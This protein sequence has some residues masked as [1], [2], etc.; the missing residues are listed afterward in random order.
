MYTCY[1][2]RLYI[3]I[4]LLLRP[5]RIDSKV[6]WSGVNYIEVKEEEASILHVL[7]PPKDNQPYRNNHQ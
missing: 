5:V 2:I 1:T 7:Y 3:T 4:L 6:K